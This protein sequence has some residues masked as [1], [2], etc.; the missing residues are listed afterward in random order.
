MVPKGTSCEPPCG[1]VMFGGSVLWKRD[2]M[3]CCRPDGT[4][5]WSVTL[6]HIAYHTIC[7][8][9]LN[10]GLFWCFHT[11]MKHPKI[12]HRCMNMF[13]SVQGAKLRGK[14]SGI[15]QSGLL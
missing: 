9:Q 3:A 14:G 11:V 1:Q 10:N 7:T 8:T 12:F 6:L 15:H 2:G 13:L 5:A 4:G